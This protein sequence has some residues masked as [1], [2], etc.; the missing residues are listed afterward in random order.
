MNDIITTGAAVSKRLMT[1]MFA[2]SYDIDTV[3]LSQESYCKMKCLVIPPG[4]RS[5]DVIVLRFD[6]DNKNEVPQLL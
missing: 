4:F 1:A 5:I 3:I 6:L 2:H